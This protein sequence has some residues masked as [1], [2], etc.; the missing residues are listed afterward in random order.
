VLAIVAG[1][2]ALGAGTVWAFF[3]FRPKPAPPPPEPLW[4]VARREWEALRK[5]TDLEPEALALALSEVYRRYL[6]ASHGWPATS[7]TTREILDNLAGELTAA[8]LDRSRRLLS[9][10]DLVKF[11]DRSKPLLEFFEAL[12]ADFHELVR[13]NA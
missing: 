6:Q 3:R 12:D 2:T 4:L 7:R 13:P 5:R 9:A 11:A 8:Q 1:L 10:M